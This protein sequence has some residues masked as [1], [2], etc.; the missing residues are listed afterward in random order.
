M[1]YV[2]RDS[3]GRY[4]DQKCGQN[5]GW[6]HDIYKAQVFETVGKGKV[7]YNHAVAIGLRCNEHTRRIQQYH[8]KPLAIQVIPTFEAVPV[9]VSVSVSIK[10]LNSTKL[11]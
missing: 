7:A 6:T 9:E 5:R 3:E 8:D 1:P 10:E 4:L 2:V 11:S